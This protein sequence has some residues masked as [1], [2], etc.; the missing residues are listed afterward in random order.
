MKMHNPQNE[1]IKRA[2]P[3]LQAWRSVRSLS[4]CDSVKTEGP[5]SPQGF[6]RLAIS[7][8]PAG[9]K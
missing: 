9:F 6:D 3:S 4:S 8:T 7:D 2:Y 1:R 5:K